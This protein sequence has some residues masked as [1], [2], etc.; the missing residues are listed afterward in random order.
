MYTC[1]DTRF[2]GRHAEKFLRSLVAGT[3]EFS[4]SAF[5]CLLLSPS[6]TPTEELETTA[7]TNKGITVVI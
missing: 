3:V 7:F 1:S 5:V 2:M 6:A 4:L